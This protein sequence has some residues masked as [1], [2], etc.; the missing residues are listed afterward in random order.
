MEI[1]GNNN[2]RMVKQ[3]FRDKFIDKKNV[4]AFYIT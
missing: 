3:D 1:M 2:G 4:K